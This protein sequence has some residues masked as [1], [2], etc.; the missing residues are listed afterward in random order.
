MTAMH[1]RKIT[2]IHGVLDNVMEQIRRQL[3]V[4]GFNIC[5][6]MKIVANDMRYDVILVDLPRVS[7]KIA[8]IAS[9][10]SLI[11]PGCISIMET[12]PGTCEVSVVNPT[13]MLAA[14]DNNDPVLY[15]AMEMTT[16]MERVVQKIETVDG[17]AP[18]LVTSW[19]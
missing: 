14:K 5:G 1:N 12:N 2:I 10:R 16:E 9:H 13:E 17:I 6:E 4:P 8:L 11:L 7:S 3:A 15:L 18:D 19:E